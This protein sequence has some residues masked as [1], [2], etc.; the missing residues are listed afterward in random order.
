MTDDFRL[1]VLV[2][3]QNF[4]STLATSD[5]SRF[6]NAN[7]EFSFGP[8]YFMQGGFTINRGETQNYDRW[9]FT[10]GYR[11]DSKANHP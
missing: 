10:V 3:D 7:A 1:D 2:G 4:T 8:R 9:L 6:V 5:R 11:F